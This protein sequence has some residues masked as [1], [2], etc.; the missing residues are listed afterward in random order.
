VKGRPT[1]LN[2]A[3]LGEFSPEVRPPI[4]PRSLQIG[5]VHIGVGAFHRAHQAAYTQQAMAL[6]GESTWAIRGATQRSRDVVDRLRPQDCLY[7][8]VE[9]DATQSTYH[10]NSA[11]RD[12]VFA[13]EET[14]SLLRSIADETTHVVTLTVTEKGY[15]HDP[16]TR[17]LRTADPEIRADAD[18]RP[19]RTVVGQLVRGLQMRQRRGSGPVT[20]VCCDNLPSNGATLRELVDDFVGLLPKVERAGTAAW[21]ADHVAFPSTMVDR[22]VPATTDDDLRDVA[23]TIGFTDRGAVVT[24]P[25]SQ[26]VVEAAFVAPRPRWE[27]AGAVFTDDVGPYETMK[28]RLLN[29]AHSA[30]AYL[31]LLAGYDYVADFVALDDVKNYVQALMDVDVTPTL[32]VPE[33]FDLARY[34][35][36]LVTRFANPTLRHR[37]AQVSMD[38]SQKL[39]QR[40]LGTMRDRRRDGVTPG[41]AT[42]AVAAWMRFV[43]ARADDE[44]RP[45]HV[46]DPLSARFADAVSHATSATQIVEALLAIHETFGA[47]IAEDPELK[48]ALID[49]L[50]VLTRFGASAAIRRALLA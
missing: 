15:R 10:I 2:I 35:H 1:R 33:R 23:E 5:I 26:W 45:V 30:L 16:A 18:G 42:L 38:G 4:D 20:V 14:E 21:I 34:K 36:E 3:A 7:T 50:D 24:E 8:I 40:L 25:F 39:P 9:R 6:T 22:I 13:A 47:D 17:R 12:V 37:T 29:G 31:G 44:G 19:P 46:D 27:L 11:L 49:D 32:A 28:L 48:A 41:F 43:S